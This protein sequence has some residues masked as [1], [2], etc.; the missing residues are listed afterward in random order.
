MKEELEEELRREEKQLSN[1]MYEEEIRNE[2]M[3]LE[4][5]K[6]FKMKGE[7]QTSKGLSAIRAKL[8]KLTISKFNGTIIDW[9]RFWDSSRN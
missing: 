6:E 1:Q 3:K 8:P 7:Y 4:V 2:R 5:R 9:L